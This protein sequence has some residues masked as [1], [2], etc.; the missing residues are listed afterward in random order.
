MSVTVAS[1]EGTFDVDLLGRIYS[2]YNQVSAIGR[3]FVK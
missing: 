1:A 2:V 3:G